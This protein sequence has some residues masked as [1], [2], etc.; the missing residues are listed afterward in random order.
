[1]TRIN[2]WQLKPDTLE[3]RHKYLTSGSEESSEGLVSGRGG[4]STSL[5]FASWPVTLKKVSPIAG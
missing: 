3:I 2:V 4:F 1:M 5:P